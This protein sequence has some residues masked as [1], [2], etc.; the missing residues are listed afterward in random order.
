MTETTARFQLLS[1]IS[2]WLKLLG[3]V[4][5]GA[6]AVILTA[7]QLTP[8]DRP[9]HSWYPVIML[10]FLVV[11]VLVLRCKPVVSSGCI[12]AVSGVRPAEASRRRGAGHRPGCTP[13]RF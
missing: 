10:A 5:L 3:L 11:I 12:P 9:I 2:D 1:Q 13:P 7:M 8:D 4:V 6:E